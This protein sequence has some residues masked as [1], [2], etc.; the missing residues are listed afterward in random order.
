MT[1]R[2]CGGCLHYE[3][4]RNPD[5]GRVMPSH[6]GECGFVVVWPMLPIVYHDWGR[7]WKKPT[8]GFT[9]KHHDASTC[10]CFS[11]K[12]RPRPKRTPPPQLG[13]EP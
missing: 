3:P 11:A 8:K 12:D 4:A 5:T 9:Y 10:P 1:E 7:P 13:I 6:A 2:T